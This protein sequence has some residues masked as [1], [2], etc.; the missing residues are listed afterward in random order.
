MRRTARFSAL[1]LGFLATVAAPE[2]AHAKW[3]P[4]LSIESPVN[5]FDRSSAGAMFLVHASTRDGTA[6]V[7]DVSGSAEG[8]ID[9]ARRTVPLTL[10]VTSRPGVF[11][12]RRQWPEE[13]TWVVRISLARTTA[14]I[15]FDREGNVASVRVP[16][17]LAQGQ[18][19]P[20]SVAAREIDS[21]LAVASAH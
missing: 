16:T 9:G 19:V 15:T 12:V 2:S 3:P 18:R 7:G 1:V 20:R 17:M 10:D 5:P 13:G 21:T 4:W 6:G 8:L 14:I 11:A